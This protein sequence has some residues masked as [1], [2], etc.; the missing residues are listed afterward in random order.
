MNWRH[1]PKPIKLSACLIGGAVLL[2][3]VYMLLAATPKPVLPSSA[4]F[5]PV[6][7]EQT[8]SSSRP[9]LSSFDFIFRP[10]FA[11]SRKPPVQP[12]LPSAEE[13]AA[14]AAL[15]A[16]ATV[17]NSIDGVNLLGIFGSGEVAGVIIRLDN[18]ERKRVVVGESIKGWRLE[19]IESRRA[20][21]QAATGEE[22]RLEMAYAT[23]QAT[24]AIEFG[25]EP[26]AAAQEATID[27]GAGNA[28][29]VSQSIGGPE[30]KMNPAAPPTRMSFQNFYG[31]APKPEATA[32]QKGNE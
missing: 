15:E 28:G 4:L 7:I 20:L 27:A 30:Q 2:A 3:V 5:E 17:V 32:G 14:L 8:L 29:A 19:S 22:A 18:G 26:K 12:D 6:S 31:G 13:A 16:D 21:L 10:V 24:L 25:S 23:D 9:E 11:L 1:W